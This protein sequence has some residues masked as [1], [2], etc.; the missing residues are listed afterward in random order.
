M[1]TIKEKVKNIK[2]GKEEDKKRYVVKFGGRVYPC[3]KHLL[4]GL[5]KIIT[6]NKFEA[7]DKISIFINNRGEVSGF[8]GTEMILKQINEEKKNEIAT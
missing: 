4:D 8:S 2:F 6:E 1:E 3:Q 7:N 5:Y